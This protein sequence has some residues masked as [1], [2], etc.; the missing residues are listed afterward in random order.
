M[1]FSMLKLSDKAKYWYEVGTYLAPYA[2]IGSFVL[3]GL[4]LLAEAEQNKKLDKILQKLD[5]IEWLIKECAKKLEEKMEDVALRRTTGQVFGIK[6]ALT[7]SRQLANRDML[8][9]ISVSSAITKNEVKLSMTDETIFLEHRGAYCALYCMLI[10]LRATV[11]GLLD[12]GNGTNN[13]LAREEVDDLLKMEDLTIAIMEDI[14]RNRVSNKIGEWLD[15]YEGESA[16]G[17]IHRTT[18]HT[19]VDGVTRHLGTFKEYT[20][21]RREAEKR[22]KDLVLEKIN[23]T[24]APFRDIFD[25]A[26]KITP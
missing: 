23:E 9:Q 17:R 15:V 11:F 4:S 19:K 21:G 3:G 7:E 18:F 12:E 25:N 6:E 8:A 10:P 2:K 26:R 1:E 24:A 5:E 20:E 13:R 14:G 16:L 22:H